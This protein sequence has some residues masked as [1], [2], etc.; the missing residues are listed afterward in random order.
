MKKL[1]FVLIVLFL[2]VFLT[3]C[4]DQAEPP[5]PEPAE[6]TT[7]QAEQTE[8]T[9]ASPTT[10]LPDPY[11]ADNGLVW[12]VAPVFAYE[13]V[14]RC[15]CGAF[16]VVGDAWEPLNPVTG[17]LQDYTSC[18]HGG[19]GP[20]FVYDPELGLLG[21]PGHFWGYNDALGMHPIDD[22]NASVAQAFP[23]HFPESFVEDLSGR[24]I[25]QMVDSTLREAIIEVHD[26]EEGDEDWWRLTDEAFLGR[27][28]IME[29]RELTSDWFDD[30]TTYWQIDLF[31]A[32]Q[33][34]VWQLIGHTGEVLIPFVLDHLLLIDSDTAFAKYNGYY[35][36][37][38]LELTK[39]QLL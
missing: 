33:G 37:L 30:I 39:Q 4:F 25:V 11:F 14:R 6:A 36:I 2:A 34:D 15:G 31:A 7:T 21:H 27:F 1:T 28:A 24:I 22:F 23:E 3:G 10:T 32:R 35:G 19:G 13:G 18:N 17:E 38:N 8:T 29:N 9:E 16:F 12:N 20:A 26:G 5:E